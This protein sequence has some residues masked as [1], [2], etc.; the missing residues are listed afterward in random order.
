[1]RQVRMNLSTFTAAVLLLAIPQDRGGIVR[2][3]VCCIETSHVFDLE[4]KEYLTQYLFLTWHNRKGCHVI[5]DWRLVKTT[6]RPE[7]DY[8]R[9]CYVLRFKDGEKVREVTAATVKETWRTW[10]VELE[11][12]DKHPFNERRK[13]WSGKVGTD[14]SVLVERRW[15]D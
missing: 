15:T 5:Q 11:E 6:E 2:E 8:V 3:S 1:M 9:G 10:D 12:R 4:G 7:W 13:L 14:R